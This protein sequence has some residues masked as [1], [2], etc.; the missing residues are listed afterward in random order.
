MPESPGDALIDWVRGD[1]GN[2]GGERTSGFGD[3]RRGASHSRK[4]KSFGRLNGDWSGAASEVRLALEGANA[5][6][7][8]SGAG[9]G[10]FRGVGC[11]GNG[12]N[13][14]PIVGVVRLNWV[15]V[16]WFW[17]QARSGCLDGSNYT[18]PVTVGTRFVL[19][20]F[21]SFSGTTMGLR[22]RNFDLPSNRGL[23]L[24]AGATSLYYEIVA[25]T[26]ATGP[27]III[28][29]IDD[30]VGGQHFGFEGRDCLTPH[31]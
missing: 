7:I 12:G 14:S 28:I 5:T 15:V 8:H 27:N 24:V 1:P 25:Q 17:I 4:W 30:I 3:S 22:T 16:S 29:N 13:S 9:S 18:G 20:N 10:S 19:A 6:L 23:E 31:D 2:G 11:S 26:A 21:G